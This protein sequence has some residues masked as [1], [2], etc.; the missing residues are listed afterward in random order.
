MRFRVVNYN[1]F[2]F[3]YL[4]FVYFNLFANKIIFNNLKDF[5]NKFL[6]KLQLK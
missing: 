3:I 1:L 2:F 4:H 6:I 5:L